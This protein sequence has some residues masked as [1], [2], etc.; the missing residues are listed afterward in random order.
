MVTAGLCAEIPTCTW[1]TE[2]LESLRQPVATPLDK[3]GDW[4][5]A[6]TCDPGWM[7][8]VWLRY[9]H[10]SLPDS[11]PYVAP[12]GQMLER[13]KTRAAGLLSQSRCC[14]VNQADSPHEDQ[15]WPLAPE[16]CRGLALGRRPQGP[17]VWSG[18]RA[19][20]PSTLSSPRHSLPSLP[21]HPGQLGRP[22]PVVELGQEAGCRAGR[23]PC[24]L[25]GRQV[26]GG[27][28]T[29]GPLPSAR[30][31]HQRIP[32][33]EEKGAGHQL[34]GRA[35]RGG[36]G[37]VGSRASPS[38]WSCPGGPPSTGHSSDR[39]AQCRRPCETAS[40]CLSAPQTPCWPTTAAPGG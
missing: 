37:P 25:L 9:L 1:R 4:V 6:L 11:H 39:P 10:T 36:Q 30:A 34:S 14:S 12:L 31:T 27:P 26:C 3:R 32:G 20:Q 23:S 28:S 33:R 5:T 13:F 2:P 17:A 8:N 18:Q 38:P 19:R 40:R 21:S 16:H 24:D 15:A 22:L 7:H 29:P 35:G